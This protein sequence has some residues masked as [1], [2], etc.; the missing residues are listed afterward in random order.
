MVFCCVKTVEYYMR[1][2]NIRFAVLFNAK[3]LLISDV[4]LNVGIA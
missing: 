3:I 2:E 4:L 1:N